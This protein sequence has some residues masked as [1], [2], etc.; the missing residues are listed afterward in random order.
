MK[1]L[2][3]TFKIV[4]AYSLFT[5]R[6]ENEKIMEPLTTAAITL[7]TV[8][9]TK[10]LEKTGENVGDAL[11]EKSSQFLSALKKQSPDTVSAIKKVPEQPLDYGK[12]VL[13]LKSAASANKDVAQS[14]QEIAAL[15]TSS[16]PNLV[17]ILKEIEVAVKK[18]QHPISG[19]FTQNI[20]KA[21]N[22]A[23][24]QTIDQS[25]STFNI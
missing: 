4:S 8:V 20:Q 1:I 17:E 10:A 19:S 23:Q 25:G 3:N 11:W 24:N 5:I 15:E 2:V 21:I 7:A 6:K 12:A 22:A 13:E 14:M 18:S 9:A 16:L